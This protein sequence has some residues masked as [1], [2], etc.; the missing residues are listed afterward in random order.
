M[1]DPGGS[2]GDI[3]V[4]TIKR[5]REDFTWVLG[6]F[7]KFHGVSEKFQGYQERFGGLRRIQEGLRR[8]QEASDAFQ[9]FLR[10]SGKVQGVL[11]AF[12]GISG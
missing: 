7:Q 3:I 8:L 1:D 9:E 5:R 12:W 4:E 2:Y 6:E 10:G 11:G